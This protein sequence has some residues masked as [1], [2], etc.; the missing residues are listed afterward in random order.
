MI[1]MAIS[2]IYNFSL[3]GTADPLI[4]EI[5]IM[6]S[7]DDHVCSRSDEFQVK[8]VEG[9]DICIE[10]EVVCALSAWG[11]G[12]S[13]NGGVTCEIKPPDGFVWVDTDGDGNVDTLVQSCYHD[14]F[15]YCFN[16]ITQ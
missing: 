6:E 14:R 12:I 16:L 8:T 2:N 15:P 9:K 4:G 5:S 13:T 11:R 3:K 10:K 1:R 7:I